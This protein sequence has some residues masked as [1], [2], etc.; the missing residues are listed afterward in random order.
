MSLYWPEMLRRSSS[1]RP[2]RS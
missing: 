2:W 1:S